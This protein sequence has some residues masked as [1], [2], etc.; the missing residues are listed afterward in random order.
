[1]L[2]NIRIAGAQIKY[3]NFSGKPGQFNAE[4]VRNFVVILDNKT[5]K[6]AE[7]DG[8]NIKWLTSDDPREEQKASL[9]VAVRFGDRPPKIMLI[10]SNGQSLLNEETVHIL[11]WADIANVDV[12]IRPYEWVMHAGTKAEK[13]GVKAYLQAIYV[14]LYEDEFEK[15]YAAQVTAASDCV[16]G[17]GNCDVCD[18]SCGHHDNLSTVE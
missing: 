8:W 4:G 10:S 13:R 5:A 3:R 14:T 15:K 18:G 9:Q 17:C 6:K 2:D 16:G 12:N 1:M 11:D 7:A